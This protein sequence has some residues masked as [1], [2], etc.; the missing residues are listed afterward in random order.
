MSDRPVTVLVIDEDPIFRL[1]LITWLGNQSRW[2]IVGQ[3]GSPGEAQ[4]WLQAPY[5]DLILLDPLMVSAQGL[6]WRFCQQL[7]RD[8]PTIKV[9]L[10]TASLDRLQL[11][12][13]QRQGVAGYFPKGIHPPELITG[14][15]R[16]LQG[17]TVWSEVIVTRSVALTQRDRWLLSLFR[18]GLG[19]IDTSLDHIE[20]YL[21]QGKRSEFD[22]FFWQGRKRELRL[23]RWLVHQGIPTRIKTALETAVGDSESQFLTPQMSSNS[24]IQPVNLVSLNSLNSS[25]TNSLN[26]NSLAYPVLEASVNLTAIPLEFDILQSDKRQELITLVIQQIQKVVQDLKNLAVTPDQ[27]PHNSQYLLGEIWQTVTLTFLGKYRH[28]DTDYPLDQLQALLTVYRP[29]IQRESLD[30]IPLTEDVFRTLLFTSADEVFFQIPTSLAVI[31]DP[32]VLYCQNLIIHLANSTMVFVLNYFASQEDLKQVLCQS[33]FLSSRALANFRNNLAW[34]YRYQQYWLEPRLIF[35]SRHQLFYFTFQGLQTTSVYYP[36][37]GEL[38]QLTGIPWFV[39]ILWELRDAVSP[40]LRSLVKFLGNGL[41][42]VLTQVVGRAIGLIIKGIFQG[43]GNSW[44]ER[45]YPPS[46]S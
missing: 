40:R 28:P 30:K 18:S 11:Q 2:Q 42:F 12:F 5:P 32:L 14:L 15:E 46:R 34:R 39:T 9:C 35:E 19:Q 13:A 44:P 29:I 1:G 27:L 8:Y 41:I 6:G 36:R 4:T 7:R 31:A 3:V 37:Q 38:T 25:L 43:I 17:E 23:A 33:P 24:A 16:I 45:R 10:L 26:A 21:S 22:Q 20:Q